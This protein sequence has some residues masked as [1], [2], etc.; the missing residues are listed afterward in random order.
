MDGCI[1]IAGLFSYGEDE[2]VTYGRDTQEA[3]STCDYGIHTII[4]IHN[5]WL[6]TVLYILTIHVKAAESVFYITYDYFVISYLC[7]YAN[8]LNHW[9]ESCDEMLKDEYTI[10]WYCNCQSSLSYKCQFSKIELAALI[11]WFSY[12]IDAQ[13]PSHVFLLFVRNIKYVI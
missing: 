7:I 5:E 11:G 1:P 4:R 8:I 12:I 6:N 9:H 3:W 2:H 13:Q 10:K